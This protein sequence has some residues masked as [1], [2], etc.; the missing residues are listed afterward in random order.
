VE[1]GKGEGISALRGASALQGETRSENEASE[2][3]ERERWGSSEHQTRE[4]DPKGP[5]K[6]HARVVAGGERKDCGD[7]FQRGVIDKKKNN[8][9]E[10]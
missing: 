10:D 1:Q 9:D 3:G 5:N 2:F 6:S 4:R 8:F 7:P